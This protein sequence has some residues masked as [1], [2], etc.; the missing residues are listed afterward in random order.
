[1]S[2]ASVAVVAVASTAALVLVPVEASADQPQAS[3]IKAKCEG[4]D[5][6]RHLYA[7]VG[8]GMA[9]P[10]RPQNAGYYLA[11]VKTGHASGGTNK[12][13]VQQG[14]VRPG[15]FVYPV[16]GGYEKTGLAS[17]T[18]YTLRPKDTGHGLVY[19]SKQ[20]AMNGNPEERAAIFTVQF[21]KGGSCRGS[22]RQP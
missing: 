20:P 3:L 4:H 8:F 9:D 13:I 7:E 19:I 18:F 6:G 2:R 14:R 12:V 5:N 17:G 16:P 22:A 11:Q 1:M 15:G 21:G 10:G